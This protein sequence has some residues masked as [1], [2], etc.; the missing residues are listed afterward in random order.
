MNKNTLKRLQIQNLLSF[1]EDWQPKNAKV[2]SSG[3]P[4]LPDYGCV[5]VKAAS[6]GVALYFL[7]FHLAA[8]LRMKYPAGNKDK[9]RTGYLYL[10]FDRAM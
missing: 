6:S 9:N 10:R 5:S 8:T 2:P 4:L 1:G 3:L 7:S